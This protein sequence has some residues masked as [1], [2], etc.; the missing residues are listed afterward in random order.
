MSGGEL[1]SVIL[2][3]AA[4][5]CIPLIIFV[6]LRKR[7][8]HGQA[9]EVWMEFAKARSLSFT[10]ASITSLSA[11]HHVGDENVRLSINHARHGILVT[12][13]SRVRRGQAPRFQTR[14]VVNPR[15]LD[16][17]TK[18]RIVDFDSPT[19]FDETCKVLSEE[20]E[21]VRKLLG[22]T[23]RERL[24]SVGI[25]GLSCDGGT[26]HVTFMDAQYDDLAWLEGA[27]NLL[28]ELGGLESEGSQ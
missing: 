21:R 20:P 6:Y 3:T 23:I 26:Y 2:A 4:L 25:I 17:N 27:W 28:V 19:A 13:T 14:Y 18:S 8:R 16:E 15:F 9:L 11:G 1:V 10:K 24:E 5:L 7:A 22:A 12:G